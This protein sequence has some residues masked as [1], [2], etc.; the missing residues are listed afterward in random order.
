MDYTNKIKRMSYLL[1]T[2]MTRHCKN[3]KSLADEI[4]NVDDG[5]IGGLYFFLDETGG[6]WSAWDEGVYKIASSI[7]EFLLEVSA[8][9]AR[10]YLESYEAYYD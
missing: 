2:N 9:L 3:P 5:E 4:I 7:D 10:A 8:G 6:I 1:D